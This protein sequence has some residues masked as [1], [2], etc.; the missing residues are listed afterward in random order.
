MNYHVFSVRDR[1]ADVFGVPFFMIS[2]G[3]AIRSFSDEI[4]RDAV[5]NNL[6]K[7]PEDFDLY[8]LGSFDDGA[9]D[10]AIQLPEQICV[11]KDVSVRFRSN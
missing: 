3:H 1:A 5:D 4:N 10:W 2:R 7:H 9:A 11:G 8:S 6:F